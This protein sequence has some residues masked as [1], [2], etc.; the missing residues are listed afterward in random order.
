MDYSSNSDAA[1]RSHVTVTGAG[2]GAPA[3]VFLHGLGADQGTWR[4]LAPAFEDDYQVVRLDLVGAGQADA[5]AY[6]RVR[7]GSLRG[8]ADDLLAVLRE[9]DLRDVVFVGHS[10]S[11]MIGVLAA[12]K[13]PARFGRL[14]L[15]A[16]S[17]RF[18]SADGY[19]GAFAQA[20]MDEL[21]A[22]MDGNF[23]GWVDG[24]AP[25]MVGRDQP[26]LTMELTNS[27]LQTNPELA[28]HFARVTFLCDHRLDLPFLTT[29]TLILQCARDVIAPLAVGH[30]LHEQLSDSQLGIIDTPG[31]C[32]HLTAP[33]DTLAAIRRFLPAPEA[34]L[35]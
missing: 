22:A 34:V 26:E 5:D 29:P 16:P 17:P 15:L 31:H 23:P 6:D 20:D 21:L 10:V 27:F 3:I 32:A 25:L 12:I 24:V 19:A 9:L 28:R 33:A 2:P 4:L 30:Y 1:Q 35:A 13:E 11:S 14:V 18:V 7:H 8:H